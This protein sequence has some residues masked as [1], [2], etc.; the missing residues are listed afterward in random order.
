MKKLAFYLFLFIL[1]SACQSDEQT[2]M[3]EVAF[4]QY[5]LI[6][7]LLDPGD[8]SGEFMPVESDRVITWYEDGTFDCN[9]DLCTGDEVSIEGTY[10]TEDGILLFD[11][12]APLP[13]D[14]FYRFFFD[15]DENL[16]VAIPCIEPC[17]SK[18]Q[19]L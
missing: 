18:Y 14:L 13:D 10:S 17:W 15:D 16:I 5:Q 8:G 12:A 19:K 6:A 11:C 4:E 9:E 2:V 7:T 3:P 1:S